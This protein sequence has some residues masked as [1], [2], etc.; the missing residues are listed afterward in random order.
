[1]K[2][3]VQAKVTA[4]V[5]YTVITD[6]GDTEDE[7]VERAKLYLS[8]RGVLA[9]NEHALDVQWHTSEG[10]LDVREVEPIDDATDR[11]DEA[12]SRR[13]AAIKGLGFDQKVR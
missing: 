10:A 11:H 2:Y 5:S 1:M 3:R 9:M 4:I 13:A 6:D 12:D 7:A 8:R